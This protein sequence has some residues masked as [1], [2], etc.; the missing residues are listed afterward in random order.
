[1]R[2]ESAKRPKRATKDTARNGPSARWAAGAALASALYG[3][4][5]GPNPADVLGDPVEQAGRKSGNVQQHSANHRR[6][7][8]GPCDHERAPADRP[9]SAYERQ[10]KRASEASAERDESQKHI[11]NDEKNRGL[12]ESPYKSDE[13]TKG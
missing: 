2:A 7:R 9:D 1:M 6:I 13:A 3:T 10:D 12:G 11:G 4:G 5:E 8:G